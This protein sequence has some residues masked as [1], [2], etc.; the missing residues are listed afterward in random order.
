M[1]ALREAVVILA[2]HVT[3][4]YLEIVELH[5]A[6]LCMGFWLAPWLFGFWHIP[7]LFGFWHMPWLLGLLAR[8]LAVPASGSRLA[9]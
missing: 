8:A 2:V 3:H 1:L 7:W 4:L 6:D 5:W 9:C